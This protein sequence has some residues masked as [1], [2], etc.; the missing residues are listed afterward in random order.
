[1]SMPYQQRLIP[2]QVGSDGIVANNGK[3]YWLT[4]PDIYEKLD[5]EFHFDFDPCPHP[6]PLWDG[7][8]VEWGQSNYINPP[9]SGPTKWVNKAIAEYRKG[10]KVVFVFPID[11]WVHKM[12]AVASEIR[13]LDDIRWL[14][15]EDQQ[16]GPGTGRHVACF[17]LDPHKSVPFDAEN[18]T[19]GSLDTPPIKN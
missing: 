2:H 12:I 14:S 3:H 15:I 6:R 16:P 1:M 8:E 13:N 19:G 10:K 11:K 18:A 7:L 9:F 5:A 4:P 17:V